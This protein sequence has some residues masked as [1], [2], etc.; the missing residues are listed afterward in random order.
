MLAGACKVPE[1]PES[2]ELLD[3]LAEP[4]E[5][6]D[7]EDF[8][9]F[10]EPDV[11]GDVGELDEPAVPEMAGEECF[12]LVAAA[13]VEPGS[14]AAIAPAATT[15]AKLTVAVVAFRRRPHALT[16]G[17]RAGHAARGAVAR[18]AVTRRPVAELRATHACQSG[19]SG[20]MP[21]LGLVCECS[22]CGGRIRGRTSAC[23]VARGEPGPGDQPEHRRV[24]RE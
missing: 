16:L 15:L 20:Y 11:P 22:E 10:E 3:E 18:P 2:L 12:V 19:I 13:C 14:A 5:P 1:P 21:R 23:D 7:F 6:E 8:E 9:D 17:H 4:D 24:H